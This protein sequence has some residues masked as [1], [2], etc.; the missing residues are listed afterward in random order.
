MNRS[1]HRH[2]SGGGGAI[3]TVLIG[4]LIVAALAIAIAGLVLAVQAR[5]RADRLQD[6][7]DE[8]LA[9]PPAASLAD[10]CAQSHLYVLFNSVADNTSVIGMRAVNLSLPAAGPYAVVSNA[11]VPLGDGEM[12]L[13]IALRPPTFSLYGVTNRARIVILT[14]FDDGSLTVV[15]TPLTAVGALGVVTPVSAADAPYVAVSFNPVVDRIRL[16]DGASR[17]VRVN[18]DTGVLVG[19]DDTSATYGPADPNHPSAA[20]VTASAAYEFPSPGVTTLYTL[21]YDDAPAETGVAL[22]NAPLPNGGVQLRVGSTLSEQPQ[23][24]AEQRSFLTIPAGAGNVGLVSYGRRDVRFAH[25]DLT[26]A[27]VTM[28]SISDPLTVS[29]PDGYSAAAIAMTPSAGCP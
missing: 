2:K 1:G 20:F 25:I 16:M 11:S 28:L 5:K 22:F 3:A 10:T 14:G 13:G 4:V 29:G 18:P 23:T 8:A 17:N 24:A 27:G 9:P 7:L 15:A 21:A 12:L 19:P 6:Q 26:S